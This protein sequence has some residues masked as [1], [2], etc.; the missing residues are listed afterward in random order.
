MPSKSGFSRATSTWTSSWKLAQLL[1][2]IAAL[3]FRSA[4]FCDD[5]GAGGVY[6]VIMARSL[7]HIEFDKSRSIF[8]GLI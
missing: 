8:G 5:D 4:W 7:A 3:A 2:S 6:N 1:S